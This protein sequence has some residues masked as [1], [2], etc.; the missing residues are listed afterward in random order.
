MPTLTPP[1]INIYSMEQ[2][3]FKS[4][5]T[6]WY[7]SEGI[8][9]FKN[10]VLEDFDADTKMWWL[11]KA[12]DWFHEKELYHTKKEGISDL[13][14]QQSPSPDMSKG[15]GCPDSGHPSQPQPI[16]EGETGL[17]SLDEETQEIVNKEFWNMVDD[18]TVKENLTVQKEGE[19][20]ALTDAYTQMMKGWDWMYNTLMYHN[21][22]E[23]CQSESIYQ[24]AEIAKEE[25]DRFAE[26]YAAQ[27]HTGSEW[28]SVEDRLPEE[29]C[30]VIVNYKYGVGEVK[31]QN[32]K[33]G[34][35]IGDIGNVNFIEWV[36]VT[37][38]MPLPTAPK[39]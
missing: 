6:V 36:D 11:V 17:Q 16:E 19:T 34:R 38:W 31:F 3:E 1:Q 13:F 9:D 29:P 25:R 14:P 26:L 15:G 23:L 30:N 24:Q 10:D 5:Q 39:P 22:R 12:D 20:P 21:D 35:L 2:K 7:F 18:Q 37:H 32:G 27:Q 33:F 8:W 28:V 4:G